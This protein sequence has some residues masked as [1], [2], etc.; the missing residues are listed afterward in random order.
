MDSWIKPTYHRRLFVGLVAFSFLML[1]CFAI[2]QYHREKQ[3]KAEELNLRLQ[4]VNSR[5]MDCLAGNGEVSVPA[6]VIPHDFPGLRISIIND[7]GAV[8]YD[9]TLDSM[10][11]TS[12]LDRE[13]IAKAMKHGEG[14]SIR[15]HSQSTGGTYFYAAK[16]GNGYVVRSAVP[17]T[18]SLNQLLAADYV[19][20]WFMLMVT[21]V[22]CIIGFFATRRVGRHVERLN[23]FAEMAERG[24]RIFD[25]EP[26]PNDELGN[27]SGNIVRLYARLQQAIADR[28]RQHRIA[29]HEQ[30]E[31]HRIKRQLTNNINHELKTPVASMQVC[32][33]TL[34]SHKNLSEEKRDEFVARCYAANERLRKLLAD[35]SVI[36]RMED[37]GENI[38]KSPVCIKELVSEIC[39][40]YKEIAAEK[41]IEIAQNVSYDGEIEGSASLLSSIFHNL[42]D[43]ALAYSGATRIEIKDGYSNSGFLAISV[44]DNGCGVPPEHLPRLFERFYRIDKGRSRQAG[45]T[46]LGLSIVKNAVLWHGGTIKVANRRGG[47]LIFIFTLRADLTTA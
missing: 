25:T 14:F 30:Q 42:I 33:E 34:M 31:K 35:V 8:I 37:G 6:S 27:I 11:G 32:L 20:L 23:Q 16:R 2:F 18:V 24:E 22:M 10:P 26:F 4:T 45:G 38:Q 44:A 12:H 7:S 5:I 13:E 46:G 15:R 47:G 3:F 28:D 41:G 19:F 21:I 29:L 1:G 17:Y 9:N 36:T 39:D 43:N 40:E